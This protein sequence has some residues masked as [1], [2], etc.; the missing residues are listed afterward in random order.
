MRTILVGLLKD[1]ETAHK[2]SGDPAENWA[3]W[4][5]A[6]IVARIRS[7]FILWWNA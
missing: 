2:L 1:A 4:Y 6:Y 3:E 7:M 5:A